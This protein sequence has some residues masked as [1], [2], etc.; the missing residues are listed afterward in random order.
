MW[1]MSRRRFI[2]TTGVVTMGVGSGLVSCRRREF[3]LVL[4][5][6]VVYSGRGDAPVRTDIGI[7]AG[8][9][10][11]VGVSPKAVSRQSLDLKGLAVAPGFIDIHTH[12]DME[13]LVDPRGESKVRQGVTTEIGGN[14]GSSVFPLNGQQSQE[15]REKLEERFE[16]EIDWT[17][18]G[19]FLERL[20]KRGVGI[21][22]LTLIGHGD[23]RGSVMGGANRP[24][25]R[26]EMHALKNRLAEALQQGVFGL[27][28]G[29]E[30]EPS[31]FADT[32]ELIELCRVVQ[33]HRG[34]YA[35][36]MR[37]EDVRV[38]EAVEE[39]LQIARE[40]G[41]RLQISHLKASQQRN[42]HKLPGLLDRI[43]RARDEGID[44]HVDRYPYSAYATTLKMLFP[45]W[46][47]EGRNAD[48]CRYLQN[49]ADWRRM[50][51]YVRDR[52]QAL[53]SWDG[54]LITRVPLETDKALQGR[55]VEEIAAAEGADPYEFVR[56]LLIRQ[57]GDVSMCGFG[58]S[59]EN[60]EA[61]L[62]FPLTVVGSD[63]NAISPTGL[64][65]RGNPHP[66]YYGTFPRYL[67]YYVRDKGILPLTEAI[68]RITLLPAQIFGLQD[69]GEI[70]VGKSAD[71]VV[72][73]PE[74]II[75]R[76]G[77]SDPHRYPDGIETVI[78]NGEIAVHRGEHTGTL[79]GRVLRHPGVTPG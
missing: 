28:T 59:E 3:D 72:F 61:V 54:V 10:A 77:F 7:S 32:G 15:R 56:E 35:T 49:P 23:L 44:V 27:S 73:D 16:L 63:G 40:T 65:G 26:D 31:S 45:P 14:C 55:S 53:G 60:T 9:I 30:Y 20:R 58:M 76:A 41:V 51:P 70:S 4:R 52:V 1:R 13:L 67:G 64:L 24:P 42:W 50:L 18:A 29:L 22:Y 12:T 69:R 79:A 66:R 37:N 38:E 17:D 47:R 5:N 78:I 36:H 71:L 39:A 21:N 33:Q 43:A 6:G 75:D 74:R 2:Q 19:G 11:A 57:G 46:S 25:T 48:F 68:R 34:V 8:R 62:A